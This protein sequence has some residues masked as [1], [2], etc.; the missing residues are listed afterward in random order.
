VRVVLFDTEGKVRAV[1]S[2]S[3]AAAGP[4]LVRADIS[5]LDSDIYYCFIKTK[6]GSTCRKIIIIK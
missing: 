2:D 6:A 4:H 1:L 5:D 3:R